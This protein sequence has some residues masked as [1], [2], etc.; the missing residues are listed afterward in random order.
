[1]AKPDV[2]Q[3]KPVL[4]TAK[5]VALL[6]PRS[7]TFDAVASALSLKLS[8]EQAGKTV[9]IA[10]PE[11][12]TVEYNR[13]IGVNSITT[14]FGS[15]NFVI[16]FPGQTEA[17]DKVSY[18]IEAGQLQLVITPKPG[19]TGIDHRLLRY[20]SAGIQAELVITIGVDQLADLGQIYSDIRDFLPTTTV[21]SLSHIQ[22]LENYTPTQIHNVGASSLSE[23]TTHLLTDLGL[24]LTPDCAT[25]L[26]S[27]LETSTNH[28]QSNLVTAGTFEAAALLFRQGAKRQDI[29]SGAN[30]PTGS[31]PQAPVVQPVTPTPIQSNLQGFGTDS[32]PVQPAPDWYEPKVFRGTN[33]S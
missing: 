30:L 17:V 29:F 9:T 4:D 18:N 32:Q 2:S 13:L 26:L 6:L 24:H 14:S 8:L 28:Y 27:G 12:M 5:L 21:V 25:N 20:T 1:M 16:S 7:P 31:I 19:T 33:L 15:R 22:P 10:C 11:P 23:L 3:L